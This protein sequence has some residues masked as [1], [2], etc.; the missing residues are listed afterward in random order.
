MVRVNYDEK[1]LM[2][3]LRVYRGPED[4]ERVTVAPPPSSPAP[5][6]PEPTYERIPVFSM[7]LFHGHKADLWLFSGCALRILWFGVP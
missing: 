3:A 2:D 6:T 1:C 5:P 4:E 7:L